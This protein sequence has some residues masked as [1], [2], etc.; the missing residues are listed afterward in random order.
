MTSARLAPL[1]LAIG[2]ILLFAHEDSAATGRPHAKPRPQPQ[3][4]AISN[5]TRLL[6]IAPH[7]D[8][9]VLG[10]GGLMRQVN[11]AGGQV[12][13]AYVT[14][15]DGYPEGVQLE[16]HDRKLSGKDF[17][18]YGR[19]RQ[20]EARAALSALGLGADAA[21]FLSFPDQGLCKLIRTYWSERRRPFRS[22][23]TR[24][25]RPPNAE[26][27]VPDTEYRG[28]DLTQELARIIGDFR[29]TI[30]L[31]PRK[32]DQHPDHCAA[33]YFVVD[34]LGDVRRVQPDFT[35]DLLNY[36][37]HYNEWPSDD[38]R[39]AMPPP[40]GLRGGASG[41]CTCRCRRRT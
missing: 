39:T 36:I 7:P 9:E 30:I 2:A 28:E 4:P 1:V 25:D 22:P 14:D 3:P 10:A 41:G 34:A 32:E 31:V 26:V 23:Y 38:A 24:R 35:T 16:E 6:V 33:W 17:R 15:G 11:A 20:K 37:I 27:L 19:K 8:D 13:V 21:T 29:P 12:R 5:D 40:R 18:G